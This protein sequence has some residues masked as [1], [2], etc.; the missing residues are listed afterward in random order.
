MED[1]VICVYPRSFDANSGNCSSSF[2][3]DHSL[4]V[5]T[6]TAPLV[7]AHVCLASL[8]M[9]LLV[10]TNCKEA[11]IP[12]LIRSAVLLNFFCAVLA[13]IFE[14]EGM[15][16][17]KGL[18]SFEGRLHYSILCSGVHFAFVSAGLMNLTIGLTILLQDEGAKKLKRLTALTFAIQVV[19]FFL[20]NGLIWF[21][22]TVTVSSYFRALTVFSFVTVASFAF[23]FNS[24]LEGVLKFVSQ[25]I[26]RERG[27]N[28][29]TGI[30]P[31]QDFLV[32]KFEKVKIFRLRIL[33]VIIILFCTLIP[34]CFI[35]AVSENSYVLFGFKVSLHLLNAIIL[36][37][38]FPLTTRAVD[39]I[40]K[41]RKRR[42][43][44]QTKKVKDEGEI[45]KVV[46]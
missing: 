42:K 9:T 22:I 33:V 3:L 2:Y 44:K 19:Q 11:S 18:D 45:T 25:S 5:I 16:T 34:L 1:D 20:I 14:I 31:A 37:V 43:R 23:H 17:T 7:L 12:L 8:F 27:Q 6:A 36:S 30:S 21:E 10:F 4:L 38:Y 39:K 15:G 13:L 46:N 26:E 28:D 32:K 29:L 41:T 35:K 24:V 40:V